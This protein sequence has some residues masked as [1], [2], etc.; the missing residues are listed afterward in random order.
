VAVRNKLEKSVNGTVNIGSLENLNKACKYGERDFRTNRITELDVI[1]R[2]P[3]TFPVFLGC[4]T[5]S[6]P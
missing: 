4:I 2:K 5:G 1:I 6:L 3:R